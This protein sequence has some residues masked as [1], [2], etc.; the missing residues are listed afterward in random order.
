MTI[1]RPAFLALFVVSTIPAGSAQV[2]YQAGGTPEVGGVRHLCLIYHGNDRR[3]TWTPE[4]MLPYVTYVDE[5]GTPTDWFF[6]SLLFIEYANSRGVWFHHYLQGKPQATA[7]DW[8]WLADCWFRENS[9]LIGAERAVENAGKT[10]KQPDHTVNIVITMPV[11]LEPVKSFGPLPGID[12]Q[13]DFSKPA[14]RQQALEWYI[15]RVTKTWATKHYKHLR[16]VGFYWTSETIGPADAALVKQTSDYL[17]AR[18]YK[19]FWIPYFG[20]K[21]LDKWR[22]R[23]IDAAMLQPNYFF[24]E[25]ISPD[26]LTQ[27]AERA[28]KAGCGIELE[29][30]ARAFESPEREERFWA[31]L[32][33]GVKYG[34]MKHALL[35]YYEGGK[36]VKLFAETPGNGRAM[37]DA[38]YRFVKGTYTPVGRTTLP[39]MASD[40]IPQ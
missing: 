12:R 21:G 15:D 7:E 40:K 17:H 5:R 16:L 1:A 20:A 27:A 26:R 36:M 32:D 28:A 4:A 39:E 3:V 25:K 18:G 10:L 13:L 30:D 22:E 9:G 33:A 35:G 2:H 37:Y 11:P 8:V 29:V 19:L 24:P 23:G 34:W 31:Y 14:D 38:L 6:D